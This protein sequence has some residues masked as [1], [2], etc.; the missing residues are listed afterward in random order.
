M[1]L[2][3]HPFCFWVVFMCFVLVRE[4]KIFS[5]KTKLREGKVIPFLRPISA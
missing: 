3:F 1:Y 4:F 5:L 2:L